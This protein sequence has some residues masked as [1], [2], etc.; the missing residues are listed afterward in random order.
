M[1]ASFTIYSLTIK[2]KDLLRN[3]SVIHGGLYSLYSF[4][5][6]GAN[7]LLLILL[8][9]YIKPAEYGKLSMFSTI[10]MVVSFFLGFSSS[11][12]IGNSFFQ[13]SEFEFKKD[14]TSIFVLHILSALFLC[15][16]IYFAS[17]I[18]EKYT[19]LPSNIINYVVLISLSNALL[20]MTQVLLRIRENV[21]GYGIL[22]LSNAIFNFV[23][24]LLFVIILKQDWIGRVNAF[25]ITSVIFALFSVFYYVKKKLFEL[26]FSVERYKVI[27]LWSIPLIPHLATTWLRHGCDQYI[28][29]Y[30]Y[31]TYEVGVFSF[32]LTLVSVI[33]IIGD[34]FNA[35]SSVS[36]YKILSSGEN[37]IERLKRLRKFLLGVFT[38]ILL[39]FVPLLSFAIW[40][41]L[42]KYHESIPYFWLLSL[43]GY[44][45]CLYFIYVNYLFYFN[46]TKSIMYITFCSSILHL[47]LSLLFT[48]YS[49]YYTALIYI[50]VQGFIVLLVT[51]Q[52]RK[53]LKLNNLL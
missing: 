17:P 53:L 20:I 36:L 2:A 39:A 29:N 45:T 44:L 13:K 25:V 28:I 1:I 30:H 32:A 3:R 18:I 31:S 10:I 12:Y 19:S 37:K 21:V 15:V 46:K 7:F 51:Y 52:G 50:I 5:G 49:L 16:L 6:K 27:L 4:I 34:A 40:F 43:Y 23:L 42:P 47:A 14:F 48:Q 26:D 8:A 11:G 38:L 35:T 24:S 22:S 41:F 33:C 9:N